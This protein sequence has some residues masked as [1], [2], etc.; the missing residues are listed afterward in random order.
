MAIKTSNYYKLDSNIDG[1][2][3]DEQGSVIT[4]KDMIGV[5]GGTDGPAAYPLSTA[6][7]SSLSQ[8]DI[9][10]LTSKGLSPDQIKN[11]NGHG[12]L[13]DK[14]GKQIAQ[15]GQMFFK[16]GLGN[17]STLNGFTNSTKS[18]QED[19]NILR[20]KDSSL[21]NAGYTSSLGITLDELL[22]T[23]S[24][25]AVSF[26][27]GNVLQLSRNYKVG[28]SSVDMPTI[29]LA[30]DAVVWIVGRVTVSGSGTIQIYHKNSDTVLDVVKFDHPL[31][32][33][34]PCYLSWVGNLPLWTD[35]TATTTDTSKTSC[36]NISWD[37]KTKSFRKIY[38][39]TG[40]DLRPHTIQLVA[41][42]TVHYAYIN[43]MC[44]ETRIRNSGTVKNGIDAISSNSTI[45][46][47]A[48]DTP[49]ED[50]NY[51]I[52]IQLDKPLQ[53]WY[54]DKSNTGFVINI[55]REYEGQVSW[56]A[57]KTKK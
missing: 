27:K 20:L 14:N 54:T 13:Y 53:T 55:E 19:G 42:K 9:L 8:D 11:Y 50:S 43:I 39:P 24:K 36:D 56:T 4:V 35:A 6:R 37:F 22:L 3:V 30:S 51:S 2:Y 49:F 21:Y 52:S 33:S 1:F 7:L 18:I 12:L 5:V 23:A 17:F 15:K 57:V 38:N 28:V 32:F 31:N 34:M 10:E 45:Y 48:F 16:D 29:S 25:N 47:V 26:S 46:K 41:S 40:E 44:M